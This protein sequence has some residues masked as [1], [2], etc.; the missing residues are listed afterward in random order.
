[1]SEQ[2]LDGPEV[3][4]AAQRVLGLAGVE[5]MLGLHQDV[6]FED[7]LAQK[8]TTEPGAGHN[9]HGKE[10]LLAA[11]GL[12]ISP[13]A[14]PNAFSMRSLQPDDWEAVRTSSHPLLTLYAAANYRREERQTTF[15]PPGSQFPRHT[16]PRVGFNGLHNRAVIASQPLIHGVSAEAFVKIAENGTLH[17]NKTRYKQSGEDAL[18]FH[19]AGVGAT[20]LSDREVG[21]DQYI[22]FDYGRPA[23]IHRRQPEITL[24]VDQSVMEQDGAFMTT[25]DIADTTSATEYASGLTTPEYFKETALLRIYNSVAEEG[26][27]RSGGH[28]TGY[29]IYNSLPTWQR[30]QDGDF[31]NHGNSHFSTYEVKVPDPPGVPTNAIKRVIVRD[32]ATYKKLQGTLGDQFEFIHEPRLRAAGERIPDYQGDSRDQAA[33]DQGNYPELLTIPGAYEQKMEKL[34]EADYQERARILDSLPDS[35]KQQTLVVFGSSDPNDI[36]GPNVGTRLTTHSNP[37]LYKG[38]AASYPSMQELHTDVTATDLR[39]YAT[40]AGNEP[41]FYNPFNY[42]HEKTINTPSGKCVIA[43]VE[44]SK[45]QPHV[46]R[47]VK[48]H[49]FSLDQAAP[50]NTEQQ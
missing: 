28:Y 33:I 46:S 12:A 11:Q 7:A 38:V 34:I 48:F 17:S 39:E 26:E 35:E 5:Q 14:A 36:N 24:V 27:T 4:E 49:E 47:I 8:L 18:A 13:E 23:A 37:S 22:F 32:E 1:M 50:A 20:N 43:T 42:S 6:Q 15:M 45:E 21:L 25:Q 2:P 31:D 9:I 30:G 40:A 44:Q 3:S 16:D 29:S 41:W 10:D 19:G